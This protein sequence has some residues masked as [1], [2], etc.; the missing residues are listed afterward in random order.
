MRYI[1]V[2]GD[3]SDHGGTVITGDPVGSVEG[4]PMA[5]VFDL[6]ACPQSYPGG[7]PHGT[8]PIF[9]VQCE[10]TRAILKGRPTAL[11]DDRTGCGATIIVKQKMGSSVC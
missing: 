8:T 10:G 7:A 1:V 6:H 4:K 11:Q 2:V 9:P 3:K 5:R